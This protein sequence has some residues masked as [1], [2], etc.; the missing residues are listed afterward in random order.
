MPVTE[1][2]PKAPVPRSI[3]EALESGF[4][5][6]DPS[7]RL[8]GK[9][10]AETAE[11]EDEQ[12]EEQNRTQEGDQTEQ[13]ESQQESEQHSATSGD[14]EGEDS[15]ASH[16]AQPIN[17]GKKENRFQ[18]LS[19]ENR[20]LR[21]RLARQEGREEARQEAG[22][23]RDVAQESRAA[24][25]DGVRPEPKIDDVDPKTGKA[26][27]AS[28][29]DYLADL[30]RWDREQTIAEFS[31]TTA[32]SESQRRQQAEWAEIGRKLNEKYNVSRGKHAD[33]DQVALNND[34]PIPLNSV[35]DQ[36]IQDSDHGGEIAY[37]IGKHPEI[38]DE[39]YECLG[40]V[41]PNGK[42]ALLTKDAATGQLKAVWRNR[43]SPQRQFR[44]LMEIEAQVSGSKAKTD[45][46]KPITRAGRPPQQTSTQ[47][48]V[49]KDAVEQAVES[50]SFEDYR[51]AQNARDPRV[52]ALRK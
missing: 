47:G 23:S 22:K 52:K 51:N 6:D 43:L 27:Y 24:A 34:L 38:L 21:E 10:P 14:N 7:Y 30:R 3:E 28:Y 33:F 15:A 16:A 42:R 5:P 9:L 40:D 13:Q 44:R 36:F 1:Q 11:K 2:E 46:P 25:S 4:L 45:S 12:K 41:L 39:F 18:K 8:T 50:G 48:S 49:S 31:R 19:R 37:Y 26:K 17:Q 20:E 32:Q 35:V 29:N